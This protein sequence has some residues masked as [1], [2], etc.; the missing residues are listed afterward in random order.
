MEF[1]HK[2][3]EEKAIT[4]HDEWA[5]KMKIILTGAHKRI[6]EYYK[7]NIDIIDKRMRYYMRPHIR[8]ENCCGFVDHLIDNITYNYWYENAHL[9][10]HQLDK[11]SK[12]LVNIDAKKVLE[13]E[14]SNYNLRDILSCYKEI[15]SNERH[16]QDNYF[17][18]SRIA[19][20]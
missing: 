7:L 18:I 11:Y 10:Y 15:S 5:A 9:D 2:L 17:R 13:I 12:S 4:L 14:A 16:E 6:D 1:N 19:S 3:I 20:R 8:L